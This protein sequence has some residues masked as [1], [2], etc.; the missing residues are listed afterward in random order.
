MRVYI[1]EQG[2]VYF[3]VPVSNFLGWLFCS[4]IL[5]FLFSLYL[6]RDKRPQSETVIEDKTFWI[7][8]IA[9]Y[10]SCAIG[11]F[12]QALY[13]KNY[14]VVAVNGHKYW[15]GDIYGSLAVVSIF[16]VIFVSIYALVRVLRWQE[17]RRLS[18]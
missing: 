8:P 7:L 11:Y 13:A 2:G 9:T 17:N 10:A 12:G 4:F 6:S 15:T 16:T 1:W 3:G 5:C 18:P 14:E